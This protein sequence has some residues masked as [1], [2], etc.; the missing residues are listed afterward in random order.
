MDQQTSIQRTRKLGNTLIH[1]CASALI[2]SSGLKFLHPAR[3]VAYMGFLGY[4]NG[5][6]FLIATLEIL[7]AVL[8]LL[9]STRAS[10]LLLVSAYF[11]GAISAHL[12]HHAIVPGGPFL[13]F[14]AI[15]PFL[16]TIPAWSFLMTAWVG[17]WLRHPQARWSGGM[18]RTAAG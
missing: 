15:H 18:R 6:F 8:F 12:A 13:Q 14:N 17:V 9:P 1:I 10:G 3:V 16:G 11:G 4:R 5:T 7:T 2:I